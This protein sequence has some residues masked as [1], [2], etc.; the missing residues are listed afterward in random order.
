LPAAWQ[1][2]AKGQVVDVQGYAIAKPDLFRMQHNK[3]CYC[4]KIEEQ[5]KYRE[6]EHYRPK[7]RYW[8]LTWTWT[9]LLFACPDCN[10]EHKR[11]QFPLIPGSVSLAVGQE[12]PGEERPLILDPS[13]TSADPMSEI[14][15][16]RER[17]DR[18]ERWV[19]YGLTERG[20]ATIDVCGLARPGLL[21]L[22]VDHVA[23]VVRPKLEPVFEAHGK[24]A[25]REV[26]EAWRR[27]HR[28]LLS[29]MRPF[30]ALSHDAIGVLVPEELRRRYQ[31]ALSRPSL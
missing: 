31:L 7:A 25:S 15:F 9:N 4:E 8:W 22:Y 17:I 3:C 30:R 13:D 14:Q 6:V 28:S 18:R 26:V 21:T 11:D 1:A 5:A 12:P 19:P 16:R 23:H 10:R 29:T 20:R 24:N 27:A 2:I